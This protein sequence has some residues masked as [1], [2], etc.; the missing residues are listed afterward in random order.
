MGRTQDAIAE[1]LKADE[2][3]NAYYAAEKIPADL[4]WHHKH[5]LDLSRRLPAPGTDEGGGAADAPRL[6]APGPPRVHGVP[7]EGVAGLPARPR[8][9][10]RGGGDPKDFTRGKWAATRAAG[11]VALGQIQLSR[12]RV[13]EAQKELALADKE[14]ESMPGAP[15]S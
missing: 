12:G 5:N 9:R 11:H 14:A 10:G 8:A 1:F 13:E 4:D 15:P 2:L 6:R 3:E 7:E